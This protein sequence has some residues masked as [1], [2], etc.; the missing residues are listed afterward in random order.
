MYRKDFHAD[1]IAKIYIAR[2]D[3]LFDPA[4]FPFGEYSLASL[5]KEVFQYHIRGIASEKGIEQLEA[6]LKQKRK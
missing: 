6:I 2:M 3:V 1:V 5:Y 4:V